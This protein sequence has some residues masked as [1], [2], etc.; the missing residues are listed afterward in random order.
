[1]MTE[2]DRPEIVPLS[3]KLY[4]EL[5]AVQREALE[6]QELVEPTDEEK[7]NGWTAETLTAYLTERLAGQSLAVDVNSIHRRAA[8]RP[9]EANH[10]YR[11]HRWRD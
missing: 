3:E 1:M 5:D 9:T 6:N 10:R 4:D 8:R 2:I 11:P 7:K